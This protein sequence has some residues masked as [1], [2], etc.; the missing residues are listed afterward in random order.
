MGNNWCGCY[1]IC[2]PCLVGI[3][4]A[5]GLPSIIDHHFN[6]PERCAGDWQHYIHPGLW[7]Y[8]LLFHY[9]GFWLHSDQQR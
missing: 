2:I 3:L 8:C 7:L 5:D 1:C 4:S 9:A 6:K